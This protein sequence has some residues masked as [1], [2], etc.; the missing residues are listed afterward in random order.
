MPLRGACSGLLAALWIAIV[1]NPAQ[2]APQHLSPEEGL[3]FAQELLAAEQP[4]AAHQILTALAQARPKEAQVLVLLS[5]SNSALGRGRSAAQAG[6]AA[7]QL[8]RSPAEQFAAAFVTARGQLL[9][10]RL[11]AAGFWLRRA[12]HLAPNPQARALVAQDYAKLRQIKR[13]SLNLAFAAAPSNNVNNGARKATTRFEGLPFVFVLAPSARALSGTELTA[14]LALSY[15][16]AQSPQASTSLDLALFA[17]QARLSAQAKAAAPLARG[18]D[19]DSAQI[20]LGLTHR[21]A[22]TAGGSH[23]GSAHLSQSFLGGAAYAQQTTLRYG[24]DWALGSRDRLSAGVELERV[25]YSP[26]GQTSYGQRLRGAWQRQ[27]RQE[28]GPWLSAELAQIQ[29]AAVLRAHDALTTRAGY[30]F[31]TITARIDLTLALEAEWRRYGVAGV[32]SGAR[33]DHR[34]AFQVD[35]GLQGLAFYGFLPVLT[36]EVSQASSTVDL[37]NTSNAQIGMRLKSRF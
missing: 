22:A 28:R 12:E 15:R 33:H 8:A 27:L 5:Q 31:G 32:H 10:H 35:I 23:S 17:R 24:R 11:G 20:G 9:D 29:S 34:R 3:V 21:W 25:R 19:Y 16:L 6:V 37:Y 13:F 18:R 14:Q 2:A 26:S 1:A 7:W 4:A 36:A 30:D